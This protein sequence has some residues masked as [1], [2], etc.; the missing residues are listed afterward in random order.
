M[1]PLLKSWGR[2]CF[3]AGTPWDQR[4]KCQHHTPVTLL[5]VM[6]ELYWCQTDVEGRDRSVMYIFRSQCDETI[7]ITRNL[8]IVLHWRLQHDYAE[9]QPEPLSTYKWTDLPSS[10]NIITGHRL[11]SKAKVRLDRVLPKARSCEIL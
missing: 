3:S 6:A 9:F 2:L 11:L 1:F 10:K 5:Y 4:V 7:R 8:R